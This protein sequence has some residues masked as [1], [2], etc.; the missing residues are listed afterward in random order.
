[1][2]IYCRLF[3][4]LSLQVPMINDSLAWTLRLW[5]YRRPSKWCYS[6]FLSAPEDAE[7]T[8]DAN[9]ELSSLLELP[10]CEGG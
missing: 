5:V 4:S 8:T 3:F 9:R 6:T 10:R 7:V 2:Q 1:M